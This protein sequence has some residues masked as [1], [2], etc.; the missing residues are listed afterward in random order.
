MPGRLLPGAAWL[1]A[2]LV[3]AASFTQAP[4]MQA[5]AVWPR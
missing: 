1:R 4:L 2:I 3:Q 5:V